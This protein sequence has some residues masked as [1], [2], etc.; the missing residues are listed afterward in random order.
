M[1]ALEARRARVAQELAALDAEIKSKQ[2][3][4]ARAKNPDKKKSKKP[5]KPKTQDENA[6][7]AAN[8]APETPKEPKGDRKPKDAAAPKKPRKKEAPKT[9]P[10]DENLTK[11][12][13]EEPNVAFIIQR[14]TVR[15]P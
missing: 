1:A 10:M 4:L 12:A 6:A 14:S 2:K 5:K 9:L 7:A 15:S 8:G 3:A 11:V 13:K